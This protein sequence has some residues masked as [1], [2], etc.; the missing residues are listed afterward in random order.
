MHKGRYHIMSWV[1]QEK[2]IQGKAIGIKYDQRRTSLMISSIEA[3]GK[4]F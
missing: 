2:M 1:M 3:S 4:A